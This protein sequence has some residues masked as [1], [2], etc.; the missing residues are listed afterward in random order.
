MC[1]DCA[2]HVG[3]VVSQFVTPSGPLVAETK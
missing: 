1:N 2:C 3:F